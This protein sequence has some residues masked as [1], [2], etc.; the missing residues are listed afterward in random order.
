MAV[1]PIPTYDKLPTVGDLR[2]LCLP[3]GRICLIT[4]DSAQGG[5]TFTIDQTDIP[6]LQLYQVN[7][8]IRDLWEAAAAVGP[9]SEAPAPE[10]WNR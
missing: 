9:V 7:L 2:K 3:D 4:R 6:L 1:D 5:Y 8:R 10:W